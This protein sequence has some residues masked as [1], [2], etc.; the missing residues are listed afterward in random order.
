[1]Q[2]ALLSQVH[3]STTLTAVFNTMFQPWTIA[4]VCVRLRGGAQNIVKPM[5]APSSGWPKLIQFCHYSIQKV[6][7]HVEENHWHKK[8]RTLA[9]NKISQPNTSAWLPSY[10]LSLNMVTLKSSLTFS[11]LNSYCCRWGFFNSHKCFKALLHLL[12]KT[13]FTLLGWEKV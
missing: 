1:M 7:L 4:E 9:F 5:Q 11:R 2:L 8:P 13:I 3:T 6:T 12:H 10:V